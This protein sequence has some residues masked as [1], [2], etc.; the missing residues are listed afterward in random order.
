MPTPNEKMINVFYSKFQSKV[1]LPEG[2]V[3]Q[4]PY[5]SI[6]EFSN[7]LYTL[8]LSEDENSVEEDLTLAEIGLIGALMYKQYL[9]RERDKTLKLNNIVGKDI[10]LTAMGNSKYA[11]N[12]AY[13]ELLEEI[14]VK[15][16]KLKPLVFD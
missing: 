14:A 9:H 16:D 6:G 11:M 13:K 3:N 1:E 4:F 15:V 8:N 12:T 7:E 2:L 5:T 10:K